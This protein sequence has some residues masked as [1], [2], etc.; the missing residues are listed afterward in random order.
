MSS[1]CVILVGRHGYLL[2]GYGPDIGVL[3]E[4][5]SSLAGAWLFVSSLGIFVNL[6]LEDRLGEL[7]R[8]G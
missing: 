5:R 6:G 3:L 8:R 1:V 7:E 4:L 2:W